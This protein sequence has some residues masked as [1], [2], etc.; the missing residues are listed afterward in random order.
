M[1][2]R[3]AKQNPN[4]G[5]P[6]STGD[7]VTTFFATI[8][9][10]F[11]IGMI[12]PHVEKIQKAREAAF[13]IFEILDTKPIIVESDP[14]GKK[15]KE[16]NGE[17][18]FKNVNFSYPSRPG[19]QILNKLSFKIPKGAKVAFVGESG[20]G[21]ST[22]IQ[23]IERF[24]DPKDGQV[25]LDGIDLKSYDMQALRKYIGYVGQEPVLFAM[26]IRENLLMAKPNATDLE[27]I[28]VLKKA[29]AWSFIETFDKNIETFVGQGGS[30]LS[31]GQKQRI[32]IARAMLQ[33]PPVLLLDESTSA[34]DRKNE[35]EI[36]ETLDDFAADRTTV[37]IAHR[38]STIKNADIIFVLKDGKVLE[39]GSHDM[40]MKKD[41]NND[42]LYWKLVRQQ[43]VHM[44]EDKD[45][46]HH[47]QQDDYHLDDV[48]IHEMPGTQTHSYVDPLKDKYTES[49]KPMHAEDMPVR[50]KPYEKISGEIAHNKLRKDS[51]KK[52]ESYSK[53]SQAADEDDN[54][55]IRSFDNQSYISEQN[56][57][58]R[59]KE[60]FSH[61]NIS[62]S[63]SDLKSSNTRKGSFLLPTHV[64]GADGKTSTKVQYG[65]IWKDMEGLQCAA[66]FC[67]SAAFADGLLQ[68]LIGFMFGDLLATIAKLQVA[69]MTGVANPSAEDSLNNI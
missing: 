19:I 4:S 60:S 68:P 59:E 44:E 3:D 42:Y 15:P 56:S 47:K 37:L 14:Q 32:A 52:Q 62:Q 28:E 24:Y 23:L 29:N 22:T 38:L 54:K 21:K 17:I 13:N 6:M 20:C 67:Y 36:Q 12:G 61:F 34:L 2:V 63:V 1:L 18:E 69:A 10:F 58:M 11:A 33:D 46:E 39:S 35:R 55:I 49:T 57:V 65:Q 43:E 30:Q 25:L 50:P 31:G 27:L 5:D 51:L 45:E 9:G 64:T 66:I 26:S 7:V 41:G 16:L 53:Y 8:T 40:L 48:Q